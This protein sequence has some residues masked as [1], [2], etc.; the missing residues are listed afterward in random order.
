MK[1]DAHAVVLW[2]GVIGTIASAVSEQFGAV[3]SQVGLIASIVLV[4]VAKAERAIQAYEAPDAPTT[5]A[6]P[7]TPPKA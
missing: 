2:L 4:V 7:P 6:Q 3:H 1:F 5:T